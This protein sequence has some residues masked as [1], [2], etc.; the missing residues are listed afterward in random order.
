MGMGVIGAAGGEPL[1]SSHASLILLTTAV[2]FGDGPALL[3]ADRR[4]AVFLGDP[5]ALFIE[6]LPD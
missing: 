5:I 2:G 6:I 3:M 4:R 1:Q